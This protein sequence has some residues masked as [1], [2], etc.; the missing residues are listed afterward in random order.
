MCE[1]V[2]TTSSGLLMGLPLSAFLRERKQ[3]SVISRW[4]LPEWLEV[5]TE[6]VLCV[7]SREPVLD[8]T[9]GTRRAL[10]EPL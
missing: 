6:M 9:I 7:G 8:K 5:V 3:G 2:A 1:A 10:M 4:V